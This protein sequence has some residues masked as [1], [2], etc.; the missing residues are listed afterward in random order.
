MGLGRYFKDGS[1]N[2]LEDF[3]YDDQFISF[4]KYYSSGE[5]SSAEVELII[6]GDFLNLLQVGYKG[7]H[8][9]LMSER[10]VLEGLKRIVEAH[11]QLF[12]ALREFAHIP[13]HSIVYIIGNHDQGMLFEAPRKYFES[14]IGQPVKFFDSHYEFDGIR[15][16]HGHMHEWNSRFNPRRLFLTK[17]LPEPMLNLPWGS[18][19]VAE[20]LPILKMERSYI[21]KVKPFSSLLLWMFIYDTVFSVKTAWRIFLFVLDTVV[22]K[23][24]YR[25]LDV[26]TTLS[27]VL[28]EIQIYPQFE[29]EAR[30]VLKSNS[31]IHT[32]IMGH[33]HVL[34]YRRFREGK[35]Y[36]NIGTWNEATSL[37]PESLGEKVVL[38]YAHVDYPEV[39]P[40][41]DPQ[42][43][44]DQKSLRPKVR[45]KEWK[46]YW[47]PVIDASV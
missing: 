28:R 25:F 19:F 11:Q 30:R 31:D 41:V 36:F 38:T 39:S 44:H 10:M 29:R 26:P 4:L 1:R 12:D 40:D 42:S 5:F 2:I 33:T 13:H 35:E 20:V 32:L 47:K 8:T 45:L 7:V 15:V 16:E 6:N 21:D 14:V 3:Q 46:G 34:C 18:I 23:F 37:S 24:R 22:F 43:A 9:Y 27:N 17:D